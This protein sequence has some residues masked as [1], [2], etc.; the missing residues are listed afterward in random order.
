MVPRSCA[1]S[2][3]GFL[4][5]AADLSPRG[6]P[7]ASRSTNHEGLVACHPIGGSNVRSEWNADEG[8]PHRDGNPCWGPALIA[9]AWT[10]SAATA[11]FADPIAVP[12]VSEHQQPFVADPGIT[13]PAASDPARALADAQAPDCWRSTA[14]CRPARQ[15][16]T[17]RDPTPHPGCTW[18]T[19]LW[20]SSRSRR[21]SHWEPC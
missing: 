11:A 8:R 7:F 2:P 1:V 5:P 9:G 10:L 21:R 14:S 6:P 13:D 16:I 18:R 19:S 17:G 3:I 4:Q 20:K 12:V 15:I